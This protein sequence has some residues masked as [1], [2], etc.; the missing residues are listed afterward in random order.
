MNNKKPGQSV[1]EYLLFMTAAIAVFIVVLNPFGPV[2]NKVQR[3]MNAPVEEL[4][5]LANSPLPVAPPVGAGGGGPP[6]PPPLPPPP[7]SVSPTE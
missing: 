3:V 1:I 5:A 4:E 7:P 2:R 6:P